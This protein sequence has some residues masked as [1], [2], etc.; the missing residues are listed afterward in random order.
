[1]TGGGGVREP[2]E[3]FGGLFRAAGVIGFL[4]AVDVDTGAEVAYGAD[5]PVVLASV[6]KI[7]LLVEFF[8]QADRGR[9]TRP[10]GSPLWRTATPRGPPECRRWPTT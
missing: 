1:M 3:E 10:S 7:A 2:D 8:R 9:W 4:H 5:E 6:F